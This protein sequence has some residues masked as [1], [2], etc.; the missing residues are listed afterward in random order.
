MMDKRTRLAIL[1][2]AVI[3]GIN[4]VVSGQK[5][6]ELA[7]ERQAA[8]AES[9][10]AVP[11]PAA[12]PASP[13]PAPPAEPQAASVE[14]TYGL[15]Q[16]T[17]DDG[18][19]VI[20]TPLML[21]RVSRAGGEI[22]ALQLHG[23]RIADTDVPVDL[24]A[25]HN[26]AAQGRRAAGLTLRTASG[27][28]DLGTARFD[29]P[30]HVGG[31]VRLAA[32]TG[33]WT[34]SLRSESTRG[35][36]IVKSYTVD[37]DGYEIRLDVQLEPGP[38][39]PP[40]DSYALDWTAGLPVT[41]A[42]ES[43]DLH[44]FR[45]SAQIGHDLVRKN[46]GDFKK[47]PVHAVPGTVGWTCL[48]SKY[49]MV[50]MIPA[51]AP[52]GS[53]E[54]V[55]ANADK[56]LGMRFLQAAPWRSGAD[57]YR[58]YAGPIVYDTIR[59]LGVGL[60]TNVE[61]GW[62][63]IRPL[64]GAVLALMHFL[65]RFIPNYGV[66]IIILSV[67]AK[68]V[69]WPLTEKSFRSMREMQ[70]MQ[71]VMEELKRRHKG[72]AQ[73]LNRQM[74]QLYKDRRV[75]PLGGCLPI[76]IQTPMFFALYSVLRSSI[77]LRNAPFVAWIDNLAGPD[78]LARLPFA[79]PFIGANVSL[80][81][82]LMG[83][84]MIWQSKIGGAGGA[85]ASGPMAQQQ[86]LMKWVMPIVM[87]FVFYKMPSGLVIYWTVNT[88]MSIV[89]Q[90]QINRKLGPMPVAVAADKEPQK[91]EETAHAAPGRVEGPQRGGGSAARA[92]RAG[93]PAR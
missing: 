20:D 1:L 47:A 82:L 42:I 36:A 67:L 71:P 53:V 17:A 35:G 72:D 5:Q 50:A 79:L 2:V 70:K 75:N 40:I 87:T 56:W 48:Q 60:E 3:M 55:G 90:L 37:P 26:G 51:N 19:I 33:P 34:L 66:V 13:M 7:R 28:L 73:E 6:R 22:R 85:S 69:F 80:L 18:D 30:P 44:S 49:F 4:L 23:F 88:V 74:M 65:N 14:S 76:L 27:P 25:A 89:Q 62:R 8:L 77:E 78:V 24:I 9:L 52:N 58:I 41:E 86:F 91:K 63:W 10:A 43:D 12:V 21:L 15:P 16:A 29:P 32:G 57:Q 64:S 31:P 54:L 39:L 83:G 81:P 45:A 38:G 68:L 11:P 93:G 92:R 84:S 59:D 46:L 61:L